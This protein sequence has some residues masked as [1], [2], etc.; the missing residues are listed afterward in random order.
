MQISQAARNGKEKNIPCTK[1]K[2]VCNK[3][4]EESGRGEGKEGRKLMIS[5]TLNAKS[6]HI[7]KSSFWICELTEGCDFEA[8]D[9]CLQIL[10]LSGVPGC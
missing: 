10:I 7:R 3:R 9:K 4:K 2:G 8:L 6:K 5:A 1:H